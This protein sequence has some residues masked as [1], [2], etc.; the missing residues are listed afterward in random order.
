MSEALVT[1]E[2]FR[3]TLA[4]MARRNVESTLAACDQFRRWHRESFILKEPTLDQ[5]SEHA[6]DVRILLLMLRWLQATLADPGSPARELLPRVAA[7]IRILEDCWQSV[8]EP[9]DEAEAEKLLSEVFP[10]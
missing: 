1:A 3:V 9:M 2:T 7:M 6:M 8:H 4:E 5:V 10:E